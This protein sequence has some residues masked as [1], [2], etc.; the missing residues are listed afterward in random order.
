MDK[1]LTFFDYVSQVFMFFGITLTILN[2]FAFLF[3]ADAQEQSNIFSLGSQGISVETSLQFLVAIVLIV[4]LRF[5][6]MTDQI[7]PQMALWLRIVLLFAGALA[8]IVG[9]ILA[10]G[11]LPTGEIQPW[12]LFAVCFMLS[13]ALSTW[14]SAYKESLENKKL[15][16][17][18]QRIKED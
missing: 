6:L 16:D 15:A 2:A 8:I 10:F 3:G 13:C 12:I 18:L 5:I 14:L 9:F 11:W 7:I 1:K 4:L 17:A